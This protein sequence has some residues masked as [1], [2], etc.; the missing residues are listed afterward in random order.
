MRAQSLLT[1]FHCKEIEV[2]GSVKK[3]HPIKLITKPW[4]FPYSME[5]AFSQKELNDDKHWP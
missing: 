4:V 1:H 2:S 3:P 5:R